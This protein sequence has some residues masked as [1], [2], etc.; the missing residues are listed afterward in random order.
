[1]R[2][3]TD[4]RLLTGAQTCAYDEG[5]S[6]TTV[7]GVETI[8]EWDLTDRL[9]KALRHA[10]VEPQEMAAY[11]EVH[12]NTVTNWLH[13]RTRPPATAVK[14]WAMRCG[15]PYEWLI[16]GG[17]VSQIRRFEPLATQMDEV[18][19]GPSTQELVTRFR[20]RIGYTDATRRQAVS[21]A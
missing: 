16:T 8:P 13:G 12:R 18:G 10:G 5:M 21:K 1:M 20:K 17:D 7:S 11:L 2:G 6:E 14:L 4:L 15:V 3:M 19:V 9:G